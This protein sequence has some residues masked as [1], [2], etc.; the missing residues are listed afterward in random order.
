MSA[1]GAA[2]RAVSGKADA[3]LDRILYTMSAY[4]L[5][6]LIALVSLYALV[7][8]EPNYAPAGAKV[9]RFHSVQEEGQALTPAEA[10]GLLK[11]ATSQTRVNTRLSERPFWLSFPVAPVQPGSPRV[12]EFPSRH[13][14]SVACWDA[15]TLRTLGQA[16]RT[17]EQGG[18]SQLKAGFALELDEARPT[19]QLL[20]RMTSVGPARISV[21][22]WPAQ[23]LQVAEHEF[24]HNA[25][26]LDGGMILLALFVLITAIV[27]RDS[28]YVLFAAWL[29]L[30][31]RV[32][33]LSTGW[34]SQWL[35]RV[36][37]VD[38]LSE[39]RAICMALYYVVTITLFKAL[40]KDDL[41]RVGYG[42]LVRIAQWTCPPLLLCALLLPYSAFLPLIWVTT[43]FSIAVLSILLGRILLMTRSRVAMWYASSIA[44]TL[45]A[46]L[47]EVVSAALG[48]QGFIGT[49][50]SVTAALSSS[51][52]A[53]LAIAEQ[54]RQEHQQRLDVQAELE[55]TYEATPIGLFTLDLQGRFMSANPAMQR[56]LGKDLLSPGRRDWRHHFNDASWMQLHH[57]VHAHADGE[58]EI[59]S[60][61]VPGVEAAKRYL[62]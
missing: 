58:L 6:I 59:R 29:L 51:L 20:C 24:H 44:V 23:Q 28:N 49:V 61:G 16:S 56:M 38:W 42:L 30:N 36:V 45:F 27:N 33:A 54:M 15:A 40:F 25:G 53:S 43:G 12:I 13:A 22:D 5:P 55:H 10:L 9:V 46:S 31:L 57:M 35:G 1:R 60:E 4:A 11:T 34:D 26:L 18:L 7:A 2:T 32:A 17:Q 52:L 48:V 39:A 37:P 41:P 8:W 21:T 3:W 14:V 62:V 47:Y 19:T 50:N